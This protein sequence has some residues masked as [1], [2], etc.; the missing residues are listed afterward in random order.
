[1]HKHNYA[2]T[3]IV[4]L[5]CSGSVELSRS[6]FPSSLYLFPGSVTLFGEALLSLMK[7]LSWK[8]IVV[9]NDRLSKIIVSA[10]TITQC[11]GCLTVLQRNAADIYQFIINIDSSVRDED[12][13]LA[14]VQA[15]NH[16][17]SK[18]APHIANA[19][20]LQI[21]F[22]HI[23]SNSSLHSSSSDASFNG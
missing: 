14:L 23:F 16:S 7:S 18:T 17:R 22:F 9:I 11:R 8:S 4:H 12:L 20:R 15:K 5:F 2:V 3:I 13:E 6:R 10:R 21:I 1:M 19:A